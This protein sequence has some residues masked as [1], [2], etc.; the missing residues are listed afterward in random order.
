MVSSTA[1]LW[2]WLEASAIAVVFPALAVGASR[3]APASPLIVLATLAAIVLGHAVVGAAAWRV[4]GGPGD[5]HGVV[6][7]RVL[8]AALAL[9][10]WGLAA[11]LA[12]TRLE[13]GVAAALAAVVMLVIVWGPAVGEI[14]ARASASPTTYRSLGY[15][16]SPPFSASVVLGLDVI[17]APGLYGLVPASQLEMHMTTWNW[18]AGGLALTGS[19]L[20]SVALVG[21]RRRRA[22]ALAAALALVAGTAACNKKQDDAAKA[23]DKVAPAPTTPTPP[24]PTPTPPTPTTPNANPAATDIDAAINRGVDALVKARGADGQIGGHPGT[25]ALAAMAL[26]AAGVG[27]DD[28]KLQPSLAVL[29]TLAKPDGSIHD[30]E[31]PVYVT[32]MSTVA[33]QGA[34]AY[35]ELVAKAQRWLADKQFAEKNKIDTKDTNYGGIGYGVD[36]TEPKADLSNLEVALDALKDSQLADK[37]EV[38]KRAQRFIERCQNRTESNDQKWASNDGGFVYEPGSS[39]AGGTTS[40]GSMTYVGIAGFLYTAADSK[41]PRVAAALDW[42]KG[43]YSVDENPGLGQKGLYFHFHMMG[44]ALGLV[45]QRTITDSDG[46]AHDWPVELAAKV[47]GLQKADGTWAN[48]DG[49][50]WESNPV[51]A[52]ARSVLALA[53]A[54]AAMK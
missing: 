2:L 36:V 38:M 9:A 15:A 41:D 40:S 13:P 52:T 39:K 49:T 25:T 33:F 32:A 26:V 30:K 31:Y 8:F 29:A 48:P 1:A 28:P 37:D 14:V 53:Y 17:H 46:R 12:R 3:R 50:Y 22:T 5:A 44:R 45:G 16:L 18:T 11:S 21:R 4:A 34:G 20:S 43:H 10:G 35:P 27:K 42:V 23:P 51:M 19:L 6:V 24:V 47:I 54:R 7:T